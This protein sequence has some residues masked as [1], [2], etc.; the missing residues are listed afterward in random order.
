M[1][2]QSENISIAKPLTIGFLALFILVA[3]F[4]SWSIISHISGAVIASGRIEVDQN[5]QVIQH[6]DGGIVQSI[7][8][9]EGDMVEAGDVLLVL[10]DTLIRSEIAVQEGK[11]F[12]LMARR[13]RLSSERDDSDAIAF[14]EEL[15]AAATSNRAIQ[16]LVDGQTRLFEVRK[17]SLQQEID[18]LGKRKS[19]IA[20]QI[21][22]IS[23]QSTALVSQ[24]AL[25][26]QELQSQQALLDKG[27]SQ[28]A[29]VLSLQ[30]EQA[31]LQG[32]VGELQ[33]AKAQAEGRITELEIE[34]LKLKTTRHE[35]AISQLRDLQFSERE[36][37]EAR[38]VQQVLLE[39]LNI[40]APVSGVVYGLTV[41]AERSVIRPAEPL[42]FLVPQ[43][44][45]L[46]ITAQIEPMHI[47][48]VNV[49]Q[50]VILR[51]STFD[52]KTTPELNGRVHQISADIFTDDVTN[53]G[54]YRAEILLN[55]GELQK[56]PDNQTLLPGMPVES[57]LKTTDRTPL[58]YLVQPLSDYFAKAFRES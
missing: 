25:I 23:A 17:V 52:Q 6:L 13:A 31:R 56:L 44:R 55:D 54:F 42:L 4:G 49:G 41:F 53:Q 15:L 39:R 29:R 34:V 36:V 24:L 10:D 14:D 46:V 48:Q 50:D 9:D 51:F 40:R 19:Q 3:G 7:L 2:D 28:A 12:E 20:D 58:E 33:A 22:G 1:T 57:F 38:K 43:D 26:A 47:E 8:V 27:L 21:D 35:A 11:L 30:R 32:Q 5:R 16:D 18:Q 37:F 45:P